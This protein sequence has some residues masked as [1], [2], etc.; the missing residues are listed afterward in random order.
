MEIFLSPELLKGK[1]QEV[2]ELMSRHE[3]NLASLARIIASLDEVWK[4]KAQTSFVQKYEGMQPT[5]KQFTTIM[6]EYA[7]DMER[8]ANEMIAKD[9]ELAS[10]N[11]SAFGGI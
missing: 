3:E 4:G 7:R 10:Q 2:K 9:Q 6:D 1:E 11:S 8:T 5:L